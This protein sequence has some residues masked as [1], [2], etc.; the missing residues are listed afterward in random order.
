MSEGVTDAASVRKTLRNLM[1]SVF[2]GMPM[3]RH[4]SHWSN[5]MLSPALVLAVALCGAQQ[6][7]AA[8]EHEPKAAAEVHAEK[9]AAASHAAGK[10]G[11]G[12]ASHPEGVP[13]SFKADLALWSLIVFLIF[14][15]VLKKF[16][17]GPLSVALDQREGTIRQNIADAEMARIKAEKMLAAHAEKLD[18]V[19][20][21]VRAIIAEARRDAEHTKNDIIATAQKEAEATRQRAIADIERARDQALDELFAHMSQR[22]VEATESVVGRSLTGSD[23]ERLIQEALTGFAQRRT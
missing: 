11:H 16:A 23:H 13:L 22:I 6:S 17:W 18:K 9:P 2:E 3:C 7:F 19:Q 5:V 8:Q 21:E 4:W 1:P 12:T 15:A 14:L 20:D 10:D